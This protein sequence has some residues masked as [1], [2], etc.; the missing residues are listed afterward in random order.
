MNVVLGYR[1]QKHRLNGCLVQ[2]NL[3]TYESSC[4]AHHEGQ[5]QMDNV[6]LEQLHPE[7]VL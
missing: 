2:S 5:P 3:Q 6:L 7:H 1:L 4:C